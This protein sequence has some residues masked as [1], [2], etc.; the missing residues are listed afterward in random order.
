MQFEEY[1]P[2]F[3]SVTELFNPRSWGSERGNVWED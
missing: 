1:E 3:P 2:V